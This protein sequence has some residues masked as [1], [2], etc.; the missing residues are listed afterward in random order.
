LGTPGAGVLYGRSG[1][2]DDLRSGVRYNVGIWLD[3]ARTLGVQ[4]GGFFLGDSSAHTAFSSTGDPI[5]ARPFVN[6]LTKAPASQLAAFP[7]VVAGSIGIGHTNSVDGFDVALRGNMCC[8]MNWRLD[9][10]LGYRYLRIEDGLAISENLAVGPLGPGSLGVPAGTNL[11]V[12]DRF[13]TTNIFH[14]L[15]TGIA[16]EYRLGNGW[17]VSGTGKASLGWIDQMI[18]VAGGTTVIFPGLAP[19]SNIG[20]LLALGSNIGRHAQSNAVIIPELNMNLG[21]QVTQNLRIRAGYNFLYIS[22]VARP[23]NIIDTTINPG[24]LPP[25]TGA[26]TPARPAV[27]SDR[28]D[29]ILHGINAGLELRF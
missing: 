18:N 20:G 8:A 4:T 1:V 28:A 25:A 26:A 7:D 3:P 29:F 10:L 24:L 23:G 13:Q 17:Y 9:A 6:A 14:G 27:Q 5:L 16:G 19:V 22:T 11:I 12:V 21:Y 2:G 15:Q